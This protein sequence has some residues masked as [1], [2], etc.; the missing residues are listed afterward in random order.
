MKKPKLKKADL[1]QFTGTED[2]YQHS[3]VRNILYTDGIRH[4]AS[5]GEA[6]WLID[7]IALMQTEQQFR[8]CEFQVWTLTVDLEKSTAVLTCENGNSHVF[9]EKKIS[10][11]DF[12]LDEIKIYFVNNVIL[13]PSEY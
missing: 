11:T 9:Y 10:Y 12:P 13:L 5:E 1:A 6:Y 7:E 2:W 8:I 3:Y 4:I